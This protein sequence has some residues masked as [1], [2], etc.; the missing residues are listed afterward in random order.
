M[1]MTVNPVR[2]MKKLEK[3]LRRWCADPTTD[4][5]DKLD[6]SL[7]KEFASTRPRAAAVAAGQLDTLAHWHAQHGA[8]AIL[9]G[10]VEGWASIDRTLHYRWWVLRIQRDTTQ[11]GDVA[12]LLAHA[13]AFEEDSMAEWVAEM[14]IR[15]LDTAA[16]YVWTGVRFGAFLLKLWSMHR[17]L[18]EIKVTRPDVTTLGVYQ[19]VLDAWSNPVELRAAL[20]AACDHHLSQSW[21]GNWV[22][23]GDSPYQMLPVDILAIARVRRDLGL[24]MPTVEH[25]LLSTPLATLPPREQRP[26]MPQPD[27][28]LEKVIQKAKDTGF[29]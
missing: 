11:V 17:G 1:A 27:P 18:P 19:R 7:H 23:F 29:L 15:S 16:P 25:P 9:E 20:S 12:L 3:D 5:R 28:L 24:E 26:R 10:R 2:Q 6:K 4:W 21:S 14:F 22:E 13:L 8:L